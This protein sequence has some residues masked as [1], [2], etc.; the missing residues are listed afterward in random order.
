MV[1]LE[2]EEIARTAALAAAEKNALDIE[3]L[4]VGDLL[5][6]TDFF[7]ITSGTSDRQVAT[8]FESI[9]E[10]LREKGVKPI[11]VEGEKEAKWVV[12]DYGSVVVHVFRTEQRE[13]YQLERLWRD[14]PRLD[15]E[16]RGAAR[17]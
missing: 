1:A 4:D 16:D 15:W 10:R 5:I 17:A 6:I 13:Y 11:G 2:P 3:V 8:I 9:E 7:V 14:A 12:L